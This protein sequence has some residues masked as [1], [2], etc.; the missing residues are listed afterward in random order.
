VPPASWP[1]NVL[2]ALVF[3]ALHFP[4]I[5]LARIPL[6]GAVV[7]HVLLA[8]GIAGVVFGWMFRRRGLEGAMVAHGSADVWLQAALPAL[9]A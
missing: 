1:A 3:G 8:N 5:A 7:A 6:T 2:A 4:S 9:L